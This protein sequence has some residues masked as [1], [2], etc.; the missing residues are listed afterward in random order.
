MVTVKNNE[1]VLTSPVYGLS[2]RNSTVFCVP[3]C[4]TA[5]WDQM[6]VAELSLL[7]LRWIDKNID[8]VNS[9][10]WIMRAFILIM[11]CKVKYSK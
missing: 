8:H 5:I 4:Y 11:L 6:L 10:V 2:M 3:I 1:V 9:P 7:K